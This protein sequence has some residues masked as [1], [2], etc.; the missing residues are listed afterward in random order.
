MFRISWGTTFW[1]PSWGLWHWTLNYVQIG[2]NWV[3]TSEINTFENCKIPTNWRIIT[4]SISLITWIIVKIDHSSS[5]YQN[6]MLTLQSCVMMWAGIWSNQWPHLE[7]C[8]SESSDPCIPISIRGSVHSCKLWNS[9]NMG[10]FWPP[11][12][13]HTIKPGTPEHGMTEHRTSAERRNNART[14]EHHWNNRILLKQ[15]KHC[16]TVEHYDRALAE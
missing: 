13:G 2:L 4:L 11:R 9:Q 7:P 15:L 5:Q 8:H 3:Q 16:G 14:T 12:I 1:D 10:E 6:Y